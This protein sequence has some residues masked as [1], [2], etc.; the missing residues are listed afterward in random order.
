MAV[1]SGVLTLPQALAQLHEQF[2][3]AHARAY[4]YDARGEDAI[5]LVNIRLTALGVSPKPR[6]PALPQGSADP[7]GARKGQRSVWFSETGGFTACP[8][9]DRVS[10]L[11]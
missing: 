4:G 9:L 1:P 2:H 8:I 7:G 3:A 5:E 10:T 11:G 6:L